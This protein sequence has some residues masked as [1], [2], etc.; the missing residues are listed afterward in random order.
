MWINFLFGGQSPPFRTIWC[1]GPTPTDHYNKL[2]KTEKMKGCT[3]QHIFQA[4]AQ[5]L[6]IITTN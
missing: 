5:P 1:T 6:Q 2:R 4:L 3:N